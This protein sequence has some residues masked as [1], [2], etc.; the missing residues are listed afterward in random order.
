M[1]SQDPGHMYFTNL[2][3]EDPQL[4]PTYGG[5]SGNSPMTV[6][7]SPPLPHNYLIGIRKS[8]RGANFTPEE[9]KLLVSAWLNCSL[10]AVEGTYQ[11]HSQLWKKIY[12]YFQQFK[13]TTNDRT[14]KSLIHR[15]SVIQKAINK[16]CAKLAQVE[17]LNQSGMT[18]QDKFDK[19]KVMYTS[20]EKSSFQFEHCWHPLKDQPKWIW[21]STNPDPKRRKTISPSP[22]PTRCSGATVD[23]VFELEA[24]NVVDNEVVEL[25][26]PMGRK[27]VKGKRKAQVSSAQEIVRINK[28]K[29]TLS[30]K[31][32]AQ[33]K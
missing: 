10:D 11:K 22:T 32:R 33:E 31:S 2:L 20:L 18:E 27:A 3:S 21:R 28:L 26:R 13:E 4:D 14:I 25:D 30:E 16:F 5:Q 6:D 7:D 12:E 15:W 19:A 29:Y 1:D 17:G 23:S 9:D 24:G 8:V